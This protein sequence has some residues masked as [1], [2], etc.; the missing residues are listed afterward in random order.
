[1]KFEDKFP[2]LRG[3]IIVN[4]HDRIANN[5]LILECDKVV[6]TVDIEKHCFSKQRVRE[7]IEQS[8]FKVNNMGFEFGVEF[9]TRKL[10]D[11]ELLLKELFGDE[12]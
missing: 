10:L 1:M 8:A 9:D 11:K 6:E 7:A 5:N 3:E 4:E 12:E 2:E